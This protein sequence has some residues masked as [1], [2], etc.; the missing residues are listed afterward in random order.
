MIRSTL[1][2]CL[3]SKI[4]YI[5]SR[6]DEEEQLYSSYCI[7]SIIQ[8]TNV[9][10]EFVNEQIH[11]TLNE[12]FQLDFLQNNQNVINELFPQLSRSK[13]SNE[14]NLL[15]LIHHSNEDILKNKS[16]QSIIMN[17]LFQNGVIKTHIPPPIC[18]YYVQNMLHEK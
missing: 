13:N 3:C 14:N 5:E 12:N 6:G 8:S 10:N 9:L 2:K 16:K 17:D 4:K 18:E 1:L 7:S 11:Q 15:Q